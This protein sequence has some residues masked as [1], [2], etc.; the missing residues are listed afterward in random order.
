MTVV[1][2]D[3]NSDNNEGQ[4]GAERS[5]AVVDGQVVPAGRPGPRRR[6]IDAT[7]T[8]RRRSVAVVTTAASHPHTRRSVAAGLTVLQGVESWTKRAYDAST[9]GTYRKAIRAAEAAG[10]RQALA[11]WVDRKERAAMIRHRRLMDAPK[12]AFGLVK[13]AGAALIGLVG[14]VLVLALVAQLS[15][16]GSFLGVLSGVL[17][18]IGFVAAVVAF[19]WTPLLAALPGFVLVAAYREGKRRGKPPAWAA[20]SAD[21]DVDITIDETTIAAALAALRIPQISDYLKKGHPLQFITTART[22]GRW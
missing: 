11:E 19:L 3:H 22:D 18:L 12:L 4:A 9:M 1:I 17:A 16:V 14:I 21:G 13:M 10:D 6:I 8:V 15:G 5:P 20:T 2:P 7:G